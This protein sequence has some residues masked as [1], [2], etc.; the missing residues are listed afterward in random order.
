MPVLRATVAHARARHYRRLGGPWDRLALDRSISAGPRAA[1]VDDGARLDPK[2]VEEAVALVAGA[3]RSA[4]VRRR[5]VVAWQLPNSA[6]GV[7]L[8]RRSE[9]R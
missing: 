5:Q 1:V 2:M 7:V 8:Y 4:G 9:E 6:A 3:L